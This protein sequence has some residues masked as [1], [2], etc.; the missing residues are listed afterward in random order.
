MALDDDIR[1]MQQVSLFEGLSGEQLRLL[2]FG[3][4]NIRISAGEELY[5][6]GD[7]ADCAFIVTL[8]EIHLTRQQD[9]ERIL[10][11]KAPSGSILGELALI[12]ETRRLTD[13]V[14]GRDTNLMRLNQATFRRILMEYPDVAAALHARIAENLHAMIDRIGKLAPHFSS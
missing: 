10:I 3:S 1:I 6:E 5:L 2:A 11:R 8:G 13:A 7:T 4:E 14:A 12:S 9:D